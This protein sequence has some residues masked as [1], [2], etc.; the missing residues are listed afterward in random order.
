M[1]YHKLIAQRINK[2]AI[3]FKYRIGTDAFSSFEEVFLLTYLTTASIV[4][5]TRTQRKYKLMFNERQA[6]GKILFDE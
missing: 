1:I 5:H 2:K 4:Q 6:I 3:M